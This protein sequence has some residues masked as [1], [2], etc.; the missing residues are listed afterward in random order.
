[1]CCKCAG[2]VLVCA[3]SVLECSGSVLQVCSLTSQSCVTPA[4]PT[5]EHF[6]V[7]EIIA[8]H[9]KP[10]GRYVTHTVP[11]LSLRVR[12]IASLH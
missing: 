4:E 2:S 9:E 8:S 5:I 10:G 3:L 11:D 12:Y 1:V 6:A 7:L